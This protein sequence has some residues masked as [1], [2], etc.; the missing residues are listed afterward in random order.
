MGELLFLA[1]SPVVSGRTAVISEEVE[2]VWLYL[3]GRG[4]RRPERDCWL[5][6]TAA[7]PADPDMDLDE[8]QSARPE[9]PL[10]LDLGRGPGL[11]GPRARL[12]PSRRCSR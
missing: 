11:C 8:E 12:T 1:D 4:S 3:T 2:S 6:N 10:G 5:F 7:A 9:R